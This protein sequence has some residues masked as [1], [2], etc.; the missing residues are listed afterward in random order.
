MTQEN[1]DI[2]L[3]M[4]SRHCELGM[5]EQIDYKKFYLYSLITHSTAIEGS[6]VTEVEAQL[7]F[8]EGVTSS[9]RSIFEQNMNLDLKA[10]YDYG[11][12][13]IKRHEDITV[14]SLIKL[15]A[16]VMART[17]SE[18]NSLGG[19]FDAS[20]GELRK[21]NVTAGAGG[22][23][24]M[25]YLKVPQR[26]EAFCEELNA[27]RKVLDASD[28]CAIYD[29]SFWAHYELVT[30]HPWADGNGR[31]SRLL[32][33]LLQMEYDVLPTKV[34]TQDKAEYIQALIDTRENDDINIFLDCMAQLHIAHLQHDIRQFE[35]SMLDEVD[36]KGGQKTEKVDRKSGQKTCEAIVTLVSENPQIT[37]TQMAALLG[38]NR[39]AISKHLKRM[40]AEGVV[41][42]IGPDKGGHWEVVK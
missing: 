27:R 23:S 34:L 15:A 13:W 2:L 1:K 26:L 3:Q 22:R 19:Y 21:V 18:Y 39:S 17:G 10:A 14:D 38:I 8:D 4:L 37:T 6:T 7:L 11:Y 20:K 16:K 33:N 29:L 30:I 31:T 41:R 32:M 5:S 42:R 24:Y 35:D 28:I 9:K 25:N 12:A 40:Q 36:R